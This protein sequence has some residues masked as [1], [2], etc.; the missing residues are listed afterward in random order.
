M[1]IRTPKN[2]KRNMVGWPQ[3]I[4]LSIRKSDDTVN[5]DFPLLARL[6]SSPDD[7]YAL[8]SPLIEEIGGVNG[9]GLTSWFRGEDIER[10]AQYYYNLGYEVRI[11]E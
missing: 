1:K 8:S 7:M 2:V 4:Y 11:A 10:V 3:H 5:P 9:L 6:C